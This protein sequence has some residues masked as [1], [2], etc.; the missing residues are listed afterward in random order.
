MHKAIQ[1][2]VLTMGNQTLPLGHISEGVFSCYGSQNQTTYR[3]TITGMRELSA[4]SAVK[5]I[6]KW[7]EEG[8]AIQVQ[9]YLVYFDKTCPAHISHL[10]AEECGTDQQ[11][12]A[13]VGICLARRGQ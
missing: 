7:V 1:R 9:W 13:C 8:A 2:A 5:Y 6:Q 11:L 4:E 12:Q 10:E 3:T